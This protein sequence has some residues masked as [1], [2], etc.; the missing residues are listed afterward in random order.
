MRHV[1]SEIVPTVKF[2][3][4]LWDT[5]GGMAEWRAGWAGLLTRA[6]GAFATLQMQ[7]TPE[8]CRSPIKT[9]YRLISAD[10]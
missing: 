2:I 10:F 5:D 8:F 9:L 3:H 1:S 4:A 6:S 7:I